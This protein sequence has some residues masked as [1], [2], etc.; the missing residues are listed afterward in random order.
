MPD[1]MRRR[2]EMEL[3]KRKRIGRQKKVNE[4]INENFISSEFQL[5]N[6]G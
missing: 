4:N 2:E 5:M 3:R 6:L 1:G